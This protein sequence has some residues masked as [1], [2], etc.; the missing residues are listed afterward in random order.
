MFALAWYGIFSLLMAFQSSA[1]GVI[2][3]RFLVGIGLGIEL[4]TIDTYLS[5]WVPTHL[6][7]KAFAFAFFIQFLSVPA[8]A[9]MSWML[10]PITLFGLSGWRWVIIFG[11]LCS[12]VIWVIRKKLPESAR[13]LEVKG[14]NDDA[15]AV[16]CEMEQRCGIAP[17]PQHR[18][19][20]GTAKTQTGT[21]KEIWAPEYRKRTI[22]LMVMNFFQAIGFFWLRQLAASAA[23]GPGR[24][25]HPQPA[26]RLFH[27]PRLSDWLPVLHPLCSPLR[28]QMADRAL[29]TDDGGVRHP[30]RPAE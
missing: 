26:V 9:L 18:T 21:F 6:R 24:E 29:R 22:M 23:V 4:V 19:E 17:S 8:V 13:W 12:L 7:N 15:H 28:E 25:H 2:F 14:R 27:Y 16:M 3:F 11:A 1:E 10:V 5:E 30:F 20:A